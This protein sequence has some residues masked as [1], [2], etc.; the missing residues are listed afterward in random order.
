MEETKERDEFN[1][2]DKDYYFSM[3]G[4][5]LIKLYFAKLDGVVIA[6]SI[7]SYYGDMATYVHGGS[8]NKNREVMAPFL[9]QWTAMLDAKKAGL[10]YYDF[11]GVDEVKWPGVT[12]FKMGFSPTVFEYFG[13]HDQVYNQA[14]YNVYKWLRNI[15]RRL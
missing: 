14:W 2:H 8:S 9:L 13:T 6:T 15:R 1:L 10:K 3:I 5:N 11:Y 7:V 12:R 4:L